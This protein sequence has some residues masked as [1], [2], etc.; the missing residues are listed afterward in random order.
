MTLKEFRSMFLGG[1]INI[2]T[3]HKNMLT[4]GDSSQWRL[5]WISDVDENGPTLHHIKGPSNV[6]ANT[7]WHTT[8]VTMVGKEELTADLRDCHFSV[9]DDKE[10]MKCLAHLPNE[11][12]NLSLSPDSAIDNPLDMETIKEQLYADNDLQRQAIKYADRYILMS[13]HHKP[14]YGY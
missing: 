14:T 3:D 6:I 5:Q 11:E 4:L 1:V 9:T 12:C 2:Y 8:P 13:I 10:M 7:F